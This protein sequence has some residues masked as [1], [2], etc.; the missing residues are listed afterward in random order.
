MGREC[1]SDL[2]EIPQK[3][4]EIPHPRLGIFP[5]LALDNRQSSAI[6]DE[7]G[8]DWPCISAKFPGIRT[9][10]LGDVGGD[11]AGLVAGQ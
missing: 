11:A 9:R 1:A 6:V 4:R 10:Q 2:R 8:I 7:Y 3:V 5:E